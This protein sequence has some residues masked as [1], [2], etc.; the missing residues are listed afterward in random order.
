MALAS[1]KTD[2]KNGQAK[3]YAELAE[4]LKNASMEDNTVIGLGTWKQRTSGSLA[5]S[6]A[7]GD[8]VS[9]LSGT[10]STANGGSVVVNANGTFSYTIDKS[11]SYFHGAAKVGASG[12]AFADNFSVT[13]IDGFGGS[14]TYSVNVNIYAHNDPPSINGGLQSASAAA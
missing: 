10:F 12:T 1:D 13:V 14:T 8:S 5:G 7:D 4:L 2:E 3:P 11:Y 9:W 6:D